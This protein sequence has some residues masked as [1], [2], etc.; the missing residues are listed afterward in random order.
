MSRTSCWPGLLLHRTS[1]SNKASR[2]PSRW[3][4]R[5]RPSLE[6]LEE[7][8]LL[9]ASNFAPLAIGLALPTGSGL[10]STTGV[11]A[12]TF[13]TAAGDT[14]LAVTSALVTQSQGSSQFG[15]FAINSQG[16]INNV[17]QSTQTILRDAFGFGSGTQPN[18]PWAPNAYNVGLANRQ[19][20]Y[21]SQSDFGFSPTPPWFHPVSQSLPQDDAGYAEEDLVEILEL[22]LAHRPRKDLL[23]DEQGW[24]SEDTRDQ[25]TEKTVP[26]KQAV[27]EEAVPDDPALSD[28][29]FTE[30][31]LT[32]AAAAVANPRDQE[33]HS[34]AGNEN[35]VD[36]P[37][38]EDHSIPSPLV[39]S[40]LAPAQMAA[41]VAGMPGVEA[42]TEGC[43]GVAG[44]ASE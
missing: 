12:Q 8:T 29:V 3:P 27:R 35:K 13:P 17:F 16:A 39:I 22:P 14:A 4:T 2:Q 18:A 23:Q 40:A 10:P 11:T 42:P 36:Q 34:L 21:S 30:P 24:M 26:E 5:S 32:L 7:R 28:A 33:R 19:F 43:E 9:D 41:L 20:N 1:G 31:L 37:A 25:N 44:G 6:R 15:A 38:S